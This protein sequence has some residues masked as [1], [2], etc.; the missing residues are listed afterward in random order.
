MTSVVP[1]AQ[2]ELAVTGSTKA[3]VWIE[4]VVSGVQNENVSRGEEANIP[5]T[6]T[7]YDR[8]EPAFGQAPLFK[9]PSVFDFKLTNGLKVVGIENNEIPLVTFDITIPGGHSFDPIAK[10]GVAN[11]MSQLLMQGTVNRTPAESEEAIG[12]LG[13]SINVQCTNEEVRLVA[14]CLS[15]NFEST[16]M[17]AQEILLQPRWD[18]TEYDRLKKALE[19]NLK[20]AEANAPQIASRSF[21]R[22]MY[23]ANH[24]FSLPTNGTLKSATNISLDDLKNYYTSYISPASAAFHIAGA[25]DQARV[26][27]ALGS[28]EKA[29][30]TKPVNAPVISQAQQVAG[31]N[32]YFIDFPEA[33]QSVIYAGQLA[34][35]ANDPESSKI[36]FASEILGGGSSGKLFQ[37]LRVEK[38][39]TY[40][41]YSF[42]MKTR[43]K[44]IF[45]INTS[46]R[47][48][49]TLP[50]LQIVQSIVADYSKNF[51]DK[52]AETTK[53]KILKR[54][55]LAYESLSAKLGALRE[56]SK[57]QKPKSFIEEE[58]KQLMQMTLDDFHKIIDKYIAEKDIVYLI[59]GDKKTQGKEVE[60]FKGKIVELDSMG[61][62]LTSGN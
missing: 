8:S 13:S 52:E 60:Q 30:A 11:L 44:G 5:K 34:V 49:A 9:M 4:Q 57:F 15:R 22:L 6:P 21:N 14:N 17:L 43:E 38:G 45:G 27:K 54:N 51:T 24:I 48:N 12:L 7:K 40:G 37:T 32:V 58:Q 31:G 26:V 42:L 41:A 10:A 55:T 19:T 35:S 3:S 29:W 36:E 16:L 46:V 61:N 62:P 18:V 28:I 23:G 47:S 50:S 59:V 33:K 56:I 20:G 25:I 39:Y 2:T 53:N 1:K